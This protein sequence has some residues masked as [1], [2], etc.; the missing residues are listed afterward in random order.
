VVLGVVGSVVGSPALVADAAVAPAKVRLAGSAPA[1]PPGAT[2]VGSTPGSAQV[3]AEV[4]V[5]P[6]DPAALQAFLDAVSTPGSPE[7]HHYL[8]KGQFGSV[9]GPTPATLAAVRAW[10]GS[11]G[12]HLGATSVDGLDIPVSGTAGQMESA[13]DVPLVE[14]RLRS[15]RVARESP[16]NPEVPVS[17]VDAIGG[18]IGLSTVAQSHPQIVPGPRP[19]VVTGGEG[20]GGVSPRTTVTPHQAPVACAEADDLAGEGNGWTAE[21]LATTYGLSTLYQQGRFGAGQGVGIYELEPFTPSDIATYQG[22]YGSDASVS[23]VNVDGG[24]T[25]SQQGEA[26]LDI[27]VVAGLAPLSSITVYSGPNSGSGPLDTYRAMVDDD[28]VRVITT[29]W[30]LCEG[31][32]GISPAEQVAEYHL[33]EVAKSQGQTVLAAAGDAGSS[34]CFTPPSGGSSAF[35]VD[36]PADQPDVTGVGGTS[37]TSQ[38]STPS[39]ETVW[40]DGPGVGAGGGGNSA[41][42]AAGTYQQIPEA[43]AYAVDHCSSNIGQSGS[44]QCREVP[45]VSASSDPEHG[46]PIFFDGGWRLFGGTSA[47]SPLWAALTT[48]INQGCAE[49]VGFV[50]ALLYAAGSGASPPFNDITE[51]DNSLFDAPA[52]YP[53][54]AGYDLASGWGS[55]RAAGLLALY[56]GSSAGCPSVTGL[57][58]NSGP[59]SGGRSVVIDGVGFGTGSPQVHF[60]SVAVAVVAHTPTS[61]TVVTPDVGSARTL[62]VTVTTS[63]TADGTSAVVPAS[64][65][66]FVSPQ[67]SSVVPEKGPSSGGTEV[68]VTGSDF[69]GTTAVFFGGTRSPSF[70]VLSSTSLI[71]SAPP[72]PSGGG[73]VNVVVQSPDGTSPQVS[74]DQYTYALPGYW[75]V[76]SDGGIFAFG[77]AGF[78]GS[79]GNIALNRPV[80]GMATT[81]DDHGYWLVASDGGIFAFGDA[82]FHGSTGD[83][84]L[85]EP[86]VGMAATPDGGGYWLVASDGGIFAFGDAHFFGSTGNI[87]LNKPVVGMAATAD[88]K[89]Y[90]LVA[91]DGGIFAYGDAHFYGS[92]GNISLNKPVVGMAATAD[93]KGYW[94]VASDGGIFAYGDARFYGSTGN[95]TLNQPVVGMARS[96]SGRGYWLVAS[97]GGLFAFGDA[98]FYGSTGNITLS[99]PVVGMAAT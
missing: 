35:S 4:S 54:A 28:A 98:R 47:A 68:T 60:G 93:G 10:L 42:F 14:A 26:A 21:Q 85:N 49:P 66:T 99:K 8:A 5:Q 13:F 7:Y 80:V 44:E 27:E 19:D 95:I 69:G 63:G 36:D 97:D 23:T 78:H 39:T 11:V 75:L 92:T 72:G 31:P 57:S 65:Y 40:N 67:V 82:R 17:L 6:R 18:V 79:T 56:S 37:L 87:T 38:T 88:G 55:P 70:T 91:S 83:I 64:Q 34:D 76:A 1:L 90:W 32:G 9:F 61:V 16:A 74:A 52:D 53:A 96:L 50:N 25:G 45:D 89:G 41:D 20:V 71:A 84:A 81:P 3:D 48:D 30:G 94:L 46:D 59:A 22:C 24:A 58:P 77:D 73:V 86:M 43:Q 2:V 29:S 12:L 33:F 51:G 15:G 62:P